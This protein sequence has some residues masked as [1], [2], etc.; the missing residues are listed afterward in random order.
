MRAD[1]DARSC[2]GGH[3]VHSGWAT[4]GYRSGSGK[5]TRRDD[6]GDGRH[7]DGSRD[8]RAPRLLI[9][10][11]IK[12]IPFSLL[13]VR[14]C[15]LAEPSAALSGRD[16]RGAA[17]RPAPKNPLPPILL[18]PFAGITVI[19]SLPRA[20]LLHDWS[21]DTGLRRHASLRPRTCATTASVA[22][23]RKVRLLQ[24]NFLLRLP[25]LTRLLIPSQEPAR[26]LRGPYGSPSSSRASEHA[27]Q[28]ALRCQ[29][30]LF[31]RRKRSYKIGP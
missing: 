3:P 30:A 2:S 13:R 4:D 17:Q 12:K 10:F 23:P 11:F 8:H 16:C 22:A 26:N 18:F 28:L 29:C 25:Q 14:L 21:P 20:L 5:R 27:R 7:H 15:R 9:L 1:R 31:S 6:D 19:P 24:E